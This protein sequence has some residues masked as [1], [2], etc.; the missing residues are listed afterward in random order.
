MRSLIQS[1]QNIK[2]PADMSAFLLKQPDS[3]KFYM[4]IFWSMDRPLSADESYQFIQTHLDTSRVAPT[5]M[6][7]LSFPDNSDVNYLWNE[8]SL[9]SFDEMNHADDKSILHDQ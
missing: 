2:T 7:V 1:E 6:I 8:N 9:K 3:T 5:T 4:N